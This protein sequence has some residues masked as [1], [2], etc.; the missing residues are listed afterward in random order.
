MKNVLITGATVNTGYA[1]ARRF[2]KEGYGVAITSRNAAQA[3]AAA[4]K[5]SA[6]FSVPAVGYGL[7]MTSVEEIR[8]VF[9]GA[10]Q[11]LGYSPNYLSHC[12]FQTLGMSYR[13]FLG[14][15]RAEY[16]RLMLLKTNLSVLE[17][18]LEW[19]YPNIRSMQRHFKDFLGISPVEYRKQLKKAK[20]DTVKVKE[21][22]HRIR[23]EI[24]I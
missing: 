6:E 17:I 5:L 7:S 22:P 16:A 23:K 12:I 19:G 9:N 13:A 4:E 21:Y 1:I 24:L 3:K 2:A 14:S 10:A 20:S 11:A 15:T 18:A 8:E